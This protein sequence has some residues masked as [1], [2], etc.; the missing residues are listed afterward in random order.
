[1][2]NSAT[3]HFT[4]LP[5]YEREYASHATPVLWRA[6]ATTKESVNGNLRAAVGWF[7]AELTIHLLHQNLQC[8]K[9]RGH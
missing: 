5:R 4:I 1:M 9:S 6:D 7:I 3:I 2:Q 8:K